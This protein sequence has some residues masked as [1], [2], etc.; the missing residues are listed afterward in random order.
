MMLITFVDKNDYTHKLKVLSK[1]FK[2][3]YKYL[4]FEVIP[5]LKKQNK[6]D[7]VYS[8]ELPIDDIFKKVYGPL[9]FKFS[10]KN[11]VAIIE[12]IEPSN[13]L[14]KCYRKELPIYHGIPYATKQDL[15]KIMIMERLYGDNRL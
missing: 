6:K 7:G 8:L 3:S 4:I 1:Y 9:V 5:T 12:D 15:D 13:I 11:D 14:I 10:V 2:K